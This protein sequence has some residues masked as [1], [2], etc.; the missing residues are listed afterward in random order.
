MAVHEADHD[1]GDNDDH[2][3]LELR[4]DGVVHVVQSETRLPLL[5]ALQV[6]FGVST[7]SCERSL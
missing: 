1:L 3:P 5:N 2:G 4:K 6:A 7:R